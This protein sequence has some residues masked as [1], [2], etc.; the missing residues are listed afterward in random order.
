MRRRM[1]AGTR[2]VRCRLTGHQALDHGATLRTRAVV[3]HLESQR[4][5]VAPGHGVI[6]SDALCTRLTVSLRFLQTPGQTSFT[7]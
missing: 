6:P 7:E 2:L 3:P 1:V 4:P 5:D